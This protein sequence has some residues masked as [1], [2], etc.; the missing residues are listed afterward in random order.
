M[1]TPD[2]DVA[3]V[4]AGL[5]GL[6]C[7]RT[8][9][10]AGVDVAVLEAGSA[11]GGRVRTDVVDG[12]RHD[13]GFQ[14]ML[15][16]YPE[17]AHNI[18]LEAL[19]LQRFTPG[20]TVH[21]DGRF[22][23]LADPT[24]EPLSAPAA[25]R[26]ATPLDALR[27]LRWRQH[28]L[29]TPGPDLAAAPQSTTAD[30]LDRLGFSDRLVDT[31]F[32][33]FVEGT[34]FD[35]DLTTSSRFTELVFRSFF[36]GEV[37]VPAMGMQALPEQVA[38]ALPDGT[39]H[40]DTRVTSLD[41]TRLALSS[42]DPDVP[43]ELVAATV[44]VAAEA[45]SARALLGGAIA[46][47]PP[48]RSATTFNYLAAEP[49]T[50]RADLVLAADGGGPVTTVAVM[51]AVAPT[52]AP[53]GTHLVSVGMQGLPTDPVE[54]VDELVRVQLA[55]WWGAAV[56]GWELATT[57]RIPHAQ[58]RMD[59]VDL[60]SLRRDVRIDDHTWVCGDHRDT[61]SLQGALVSGR[62]TAEAILGS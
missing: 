6:N 50:D 16:G 52:Y 24:R 12:V 7:A 38:A 55:G 41:G 57:W 36:R 46:D 17:L 1:A 42:D 18:D 26:L 29:A 35:P 47:P 20:V 54:R 32:R 3:I 34:F 9:T 22:T 27:L 2:V 4:G 25:L 61:A 5:A 59:P 53:A 30:L 37:A 21:H 39:I 51:S 43:D 48:G 28:V 40:L 33:P 23:R 15:T 14:V 31:F 8:L 49:P 60:P 58:P 13:H 45:P 56:H 44:V 10:A 11:V 62:R 19:D